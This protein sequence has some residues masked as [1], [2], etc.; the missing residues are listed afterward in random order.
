MRHARTTSIESGS[1]F[2]PDEPPNR[3]YRPAVVPE[4]G[5]K[6]FTEERE[7]KKPPVGSP[8]EDFGKWLLHDASPGAYKTAKFT[9]TD[10]LTLNLLCH[11][12][13]WKN[14]SFSPKKGGEVQQFKSAEQIYEYVGIRV[15]NM[16]E[17]ATTMDTTIEEL[18]DTQ[19]EI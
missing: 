1:V 11:S 13:D 12:Q 17:P 4:G 15:I 7:V 3:G 6:N 10:I 8:P 14:V 5:W 19:R 9:E 16:G 18:K 2:D